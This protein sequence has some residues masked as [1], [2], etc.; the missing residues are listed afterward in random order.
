MYRVEFERL[1]ELLR[2]RI[3]NLPEDDENKTTEPSTSQLV[4]TQVRDE[5]IIP[6][7]ENRVESRI[8]T[9]TGGLHVGKLFIPF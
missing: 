6:A 2:S 8:S 3:V 5:Q 9:P 7:Q 1:T 4:A